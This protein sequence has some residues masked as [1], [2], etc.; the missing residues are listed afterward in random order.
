MEKNSLPPSQKHAG[1]HRSDDDDSDVVAPED[2][3]DKNGLMKAAE[4]D[5]M[6]DRFKKG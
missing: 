6:V 5:D 3:R 2:E 1:E 4:S